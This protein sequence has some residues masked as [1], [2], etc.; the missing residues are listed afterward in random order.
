MGVS[1][2]EGREAGGRGGVFGQ[3]PHVHRQVGYVREK[4]SACYNHIFTTSTSLDKEN[5]E[6]LVL[7]FISEP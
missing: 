5:L 1:R 7:R 2:G 3:D 4:E 6:N